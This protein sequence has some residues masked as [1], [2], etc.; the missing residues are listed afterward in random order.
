MNFDPE[1][2]SI[3]LKQTEIFSEIITAHP[4][5]LSIFRYIESVANTSQPI[6][7]T[8]ETGVGKALIFKAIHLASTRKGNF[9]VVNVAGLDDH[10]FTDTLFGHVR[11]AF[12]GA[13]RARPGMVEQAKGGTL[14]L[15][16]IGDMSHESQVK[17]LRLLEEREYQPLG[18]DKPIYSDAAIVSATHRDLWALQKVGKFRK[19]LNFRLRTHHIHIPPLRERMEDIP[20]LT[21]HF[22]RHA[23]EVFNKKQPDLSDECFSLLK[24]YHFPGNVRELKSVIFDAVGRE[25]SNILSPETI[26][27][28]II[29]RQKDRASDGAEM[30]EQKPKETGYM[31]FPEKLPT[32]K[33]WTQSLVDE[34][35]R[36]AD[37]NQSA[38]ARMLGISQPAMNKRIKKNKASDSSESS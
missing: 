28:C 4:S 2:L 26:K 10:M 35:L 21:E 7:I 30:K 25:T 22:V 33:Q 1:N 17:L 18:K 19:D 27:L 5:I 6:L 11:G 23:A 9:V 24:T 13:D 8:G 37:G 14:V 36:R 15:D 31:A 16:E 34:A 32:I 12:T 38:A 20:L 29:Q 3:T